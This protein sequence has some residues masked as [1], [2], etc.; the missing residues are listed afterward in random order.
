MGLLHAR[1]LRDQLRETGTDDLTRRF[2]DRSAA[3]IEPL[4]SATLWFDRHRIAEI[5]ADVAGIAYRPDDPRWAV[6]RA[7]YTAALTDPDAARV[8]LALGSLLGTPDEILADRALVGRILSVADGAPRYPLP[9][10]TRDK[11]L[12]AIAY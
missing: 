3:T 7:T 10:A 6:S 9:G 8:Q 1:G 11:L 12:A 2:A 4:Y 5:D